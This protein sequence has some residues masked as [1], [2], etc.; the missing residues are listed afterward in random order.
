M[1][2]HWCKNHWKLSNNDDTVKMIYD[3]Y[4]IV[5]VG[6]WSKLRKRISD[7]SLVAEPDTDD[8]NSAWTISYMQSVRK[9][10]VWSNSIVVGIARCLKYVMMPHGRKYVRFLF[11]DIIWRQD[12]QLELKL[13]RPLK[14]C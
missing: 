14:K 4:C 1:P 6:I 11:Y 7:F 8:R 9:H 3:V 13:K 5:K 12:A 2:D 10:E